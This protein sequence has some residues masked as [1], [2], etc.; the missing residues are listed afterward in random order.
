MNQDTEFVASKR[1]GVTEVTRADPRTFFGSP[2]AQR[3]E[4]LSE[5]RFFAPSSGCYELGGDF[6]QMFKS[7]T[8]SSGV[9]A[10]R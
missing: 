2:E 5:G 3:L 8:H 7:A 1:A 6:G 4:A 9:I 10:L